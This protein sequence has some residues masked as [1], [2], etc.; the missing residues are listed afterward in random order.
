VAAATEL[1]SVAGAVGSPVFDGAGVRVGR[2]DDLVIR[3]DAGD[4]HP[5]LHGAVI[6]IRRGRTFVPGTA[7]AAFLPD[8]LWLDGPVERCTPDRRP[9]LVALAHDV[10]DRQIVDAD[11][12]DVVRVSD[13]VLGR[14]PDGIRLVGAD[15]SART[16][17]RRLG[18]ARLRRTVAVDRV[19]DWGYVAAFSARSADQAGSVLRLTN[20]A[21]GLRRLSSAEL[22]TLLDDLPPHEREQFGATVADPA[23]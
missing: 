22:E 3:W 16:L 8:R 9:C 13:L 5:P 23:P 2:L 20:A 21:A 1:I 14:L 18:P 7:I 17:L 19:Y 4:P 15:V 11:G 10:L 6:R 12:A